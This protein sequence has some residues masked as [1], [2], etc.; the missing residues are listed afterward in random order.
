[1][2]PEDFMRR[3][4]LISCLFV[5]F[6]SCARSKD[7]TVPP[8]SPAAESTAATVPPRPASPGG[9]DIGA[10]DRSANACVDFYQFACGNWMKNNPIPGDQARWG[11]FGE[12]AERNRE[13]LHQIL[14]KA[15]PADAKRSALEQK[16]GDFYASCMDEKTADDQGAG[17]LKA[18]L[19]HIAR[20]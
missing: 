15:A 13:I 10:L 14:E 1:Q 20:L 3:I 5:V 6:L 12:L 9:F 17:P 19:D 18:E 16:Y 2:I 7:V 8:P 11:R 4:K